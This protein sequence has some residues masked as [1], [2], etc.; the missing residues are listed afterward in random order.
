M[1][2]EKVQKHPL[3]EDLY[4]SDLIPPYESITEF[5]KLRIGQI[6]FHEFMVRELI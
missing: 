4:H 3:R 5:D 2:L 1:P 6:L